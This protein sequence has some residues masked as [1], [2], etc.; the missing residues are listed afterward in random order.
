MY[1]SIILRTPLAYWKVSDALH[2]GEVGVDLASQSLALYL[3]TVTPDG[4][5]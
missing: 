4:G 2:K 1:E 5:E 3:S